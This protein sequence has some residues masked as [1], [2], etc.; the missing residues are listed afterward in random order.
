MI[1]DWINT[2]FASFDYAIF[3]FM[4]YLQVNAGAFFTPFLK[5]F[6]FLGEDGWLTI[7]AGVILLL[8]KKTRGI[9]ATILVSIVESFFMYQSDFPNTALRIASSHS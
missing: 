5:A 2:T 7:L 3:N 9:G 8:F 4:H 1:A 6:T